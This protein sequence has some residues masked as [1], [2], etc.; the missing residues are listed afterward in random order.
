MTEWSFD[1]PMVA[2]AGA[3][4][5]VYVLGA[6]RVRECGGQWPASATSWFLGAGLGSLVL[7]ACSFLGT[8]SRVLF[9]PLAVQDVPLLTI[10][11]IGLTLGRPV[12]LWRRVFHPR[13]KRSGSGRA[14]GVVRG[15]SFPLT[16]SVVAVG[17]PL[18][19]YTTGWDQARL[20]HK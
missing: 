18:A 16:G 13:P 8:Y 1:G 19:V 6:R 2:I 14:G 9:W 15:L 10:V 20:E 5:V 7:V 12:E 17:L 3:A 4:A 11:P